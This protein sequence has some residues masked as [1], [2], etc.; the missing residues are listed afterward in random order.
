MIQRRRHVPAL[1]ADWLALFPLEEWDVAVDTL[2][3][4][5]PWIEDG[6]E[7]PAG[8]VPYLPA[9]VSALCRLVQLVPMDAGTTF[10]D[11]GCGVGRA[12]L[13]VNLLTGARVAGVDVQS[14]LIE[15]A[16]AI[17]QRLNLP[18]AH[19]YCG[20]L[21]SAGCVVPEG[22]VYFMYC[23]F[24]RRRIEPLLRR[25]KQQCRAA[26]IHVACLQMDLPP[27]DWLSLDAPVHPELRV[28]RS[29]PALGD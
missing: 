9:P 21:S 23:P 27:C 26:P 3:G 22:N 29:L 10:V 1:V 19:F 12:A 5:D 16:R 25:M 2:L 18:S 28:Y 4:V 24:G 7:L 6:P 17:V 14:T 20:D 8:C 15:R 13:L 11:L